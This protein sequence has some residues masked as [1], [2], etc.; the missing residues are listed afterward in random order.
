[1]LAN[2]GTQQNSA[3]AK[4][5]EN[6]SFHS[7]LKEGWCQRMHK[8][9]HSCCSF[10][11]LVR[12]CSKSFKLGF[13]RMWTENFQMHKLGLKRQRNQGS[14]CQ[15]SLDH[16][17]SSGIAENIYFCFTDYTKSFD[18]VDHNKMWKI[19]KEMGIPDHLTCLLRNLYVGHEATVRTL[20]GTTDWFKI[21]KKECEQV[22]CYHSVYLT[23]TQ[24]TSCE[25]PGW[26][27]HKLESR[28]PG[29][30]P[31]TSDMQMIPL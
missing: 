24:I 3:V 28:L 29:E 17:E 14:H 23:D 21:G 6:D 7:N 31:T 8:L 12:L 1:M 30:I 11:M 15:L 9:L 22:V 26:M 18:C 27:N 19:I 20:H 2:L 10:Q 16:R 4:G 25:M 5:L 13:S